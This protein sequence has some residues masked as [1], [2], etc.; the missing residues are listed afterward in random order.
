MAVE[1]ILSQNQ[2]PLLYLTHSLTSSSSFPVLP[3]LLNLVL[4]YL[5][6]TSFNWRH[7]RHHFH[8]VPYVV[9]Q[10]GREEQESNHVLFILMQE[11]GRLDA[12][13]P[14]VARGSRV[15]MSWRGTQGHIPVKRTLPAQSATRNS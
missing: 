8:I 2:G 5:S 14:D 15:Q 13:G 1:N 9:S 11:S 4:C 10:R 6:Y 3:K 7:Y 12:V